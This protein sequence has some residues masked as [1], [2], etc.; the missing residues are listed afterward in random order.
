MRG[1][2]FGRA[3]LRMNRP[4]ASP[5]KVSISS[6]KKSLRVFHIIFFAAFVLFSPPPSKVHAAQI[7]LAWDASTDPN[8]AGYKVYY[9]TASGSYPTAVDV[10][11]QT[12]CA[13]A[14]L[15]G[16]M[17]YYFAATE[18]DKSGQES[19]YSNEVVLSPPTSCAF[20]LSPTAN[21]FNSTGGT[22]TFGVTTQAGCAW[23]AISNVS[24]LV[25]TSNSSGTGNGT[26]H[27][28]VLSNPNSTSRTGTVT[29]GGKTLNVT[30][31]AVSQY[32][33][34]AAKAGNGNGT[35]T[36]NPAGSTF[37]AGTVVTLTAAP[38]GNSAFAGW[39]GGCSGTSATCKVTMNSNTS[40]T[41]TFTLQRN[42]ITAHVGANGSISPAGLVAVALGASQSFTITP[43]RGYRIA[44]VKVD[45]ASV[46]RTSSYLFGNVMSTHTIDATFAPV[47][48]SHGR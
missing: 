38:D 39:S 1:P 23:T 25:I 18:Y 21:S 20:S 4:I 43:N 24:W 16:G 44:D 2:G 13:I 15:S 26:V 40:V 6:A 14:N 17:A 11:N 33:I 34:A 27:Y 12:S 5:K 7:T 10:G 28:S 8:I 36:V 46:G 3:K 19:G 30:Q 29:I 31:A 45:G 41:A 35:V 47:K 37:T 9:G 32:S 48:R 22:G 42:T